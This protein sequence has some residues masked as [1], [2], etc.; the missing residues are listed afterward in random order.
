M[1]ERAVLVD[2]TASRSKIMWILDCK[3]AYGGKVVASCLHLLGGFQLG[4]FG[5]V[6]GSSTLDETYSDL[7]ACCN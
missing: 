2:R 1:L 4:S 7:Q 3:T 6:S 5:N